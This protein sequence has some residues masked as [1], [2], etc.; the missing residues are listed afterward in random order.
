MSEKLDRRQKVNIFTRHGGLFAAL[1]SAA[2]VC[3]ALPGA[4]LAAGQSG[5]TLPFD[6]RERG[7]EPGLVPEALSGTSAYMEPFGVPVAPGIYLANFM[8][9]YF[10]KPDLAA[11]MPAYRAA[12]PREVYD[13]L[14]DDPLNRCP[15]DDME[16]YF[17][18]QALEIGGPRNRRT[19]WPRKCQID[20]RWQVLAPREYRQPVQ[21]NQ[22]L[23]RKKADQLARL[24]SIDQDMILSDEEYE[25][26]MGT[27]VDPPSNDNG[28]DIIRAC[29]DDL[30]NSIGNADIPLS[31]YGL[32]LDDEGYVRSNCAPDAPC[33]EFNDLAIDGD[34]WAIAEECY[35]EDK[36]LRLIDP[37]ET[38][39][40]FPEIL[41]E[42]VACQ[43]DWTP[44]CIVVTASPGNGGAVR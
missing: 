36:L 16:G 6:A 10:I 31:S 37:R 3:A 25:C 41:L 29:S 9:L 5:R 44:S 24:L 26:M 17:D 43:R 2:I 42:G 21:I 30:T 19:F 39:T 1:A 11:N 13:C 23:G 22:P 33:L 27:D 12:L 4:V 28:R 8:I 34:L 40:P 35:F 7:T 14:A 18:E 20:P 38:E 32:S 15:Y